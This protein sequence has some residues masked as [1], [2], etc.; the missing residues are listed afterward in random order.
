[1]RISTQV[2][3]HAGC[4]SVICVTFWCFRVSVHF[5]VSVHSDLWPLCSGLTSAVCCLVSVVRLENA[6][7]LGLRMCQCGLAAGPRPGSELRSDC[8][9][10]L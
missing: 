10:M 5:C 2:R 7:A 1:M 8:V 9:N 3:P 4:V 6:Q